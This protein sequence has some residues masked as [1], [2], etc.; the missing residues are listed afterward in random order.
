MIHFKCNL[1]SETLRV[2]DSA[3]GD[4]CECPKCG[5]EQEVPARSPKPAASSSSS[6]AALLCEMQAQTQHLH[7]IREMVK[8]FVGMFVL[9]YILPFIIGGLWAS[10]HGLF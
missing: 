10:L 2:Q 5:A 1:C 7:S 6:D 8:L 3:A 4:L 9:F